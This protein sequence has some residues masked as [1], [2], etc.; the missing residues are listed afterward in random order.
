MHCTTQSH[1][2]ITSIYHDAEPPTPTILPVLVMM[3]EV[4]YFVDSADES[5]YNF[6]VE[7]GLTEIAQS[8]DTLATK[9]YILGF[10]L[11]QTQ[12]QT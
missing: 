4:S 2:L 8:S 1:V 7:L 11:Q 12:L 9:I 10:T 6:D 3:I 5:R